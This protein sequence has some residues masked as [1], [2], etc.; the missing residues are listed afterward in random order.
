[1]KTSRTF[2][3]SVFI[4][5]NKIRAKAFNNQETVCGERYSTIE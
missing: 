3:E 4:T 5:W 1:M 2:A